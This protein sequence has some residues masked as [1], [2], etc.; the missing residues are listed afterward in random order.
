[1]PARLIHPI[2]QA[3]QPFGSEDY[4]LS[5]P[6][7]KELF[8]EKTPREPIKGFEVLE[9]PDIAIAIAAKPQNN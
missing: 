3:F 4:V 1:M 9:L 5:F 6:V 8:A 2:E 7:P